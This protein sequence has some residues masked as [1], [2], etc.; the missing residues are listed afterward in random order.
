M[1]DPVGDGVN[2][3][4]P[5]PD[6]NLKD[7]PPRELSQTDQLNKKLLKSFFDRINQG[8]EK[9]TKMLEKDSDADPNDSWETSPGE[10]PA[11]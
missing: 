6:D 7:L 1:S 9:L 8:D 11:K 5:P 4:K 10:F 2:Q 3:N